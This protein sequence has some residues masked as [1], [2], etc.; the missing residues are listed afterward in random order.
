MLKALIIIKKVVLEQFSS[1]EDNYEKNNGGLCRLFKTRM[2]S[3]CDDYS[4]RSHGRC[5]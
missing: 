5:I 1:I 2:V 4:Y 3:G